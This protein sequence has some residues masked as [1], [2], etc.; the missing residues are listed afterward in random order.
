MS[1]TSFHFH[2]IVA[3][4][5]SGTALAVPA[6]TSAKSAPAA[7]KAAAP[8]TV[9]SLNAASLVPGQGKKMVGVNAF[10]RA[11]VLLDRAWFSPGEIDG[12]QGRNLQRA[13]T[14][15]QMA[16]GLNVNG[17]L[18]AATAK[19]LEAGDKGDAFKTYTITSK[20]VAGPYIK[21]PAPMADRGKL[22]SLDYEN[23]REALAERF[24]ISEAMLVSLNRGRT[25]EF[26]AG[27]E[28]IVP[29]VTPKPPVEGAAKKI[30]IDKSS[31]TLW[32]LGAE[33]KVLGVFPISIGGPQDP[34]P[35]G[36]MKIVNEVPNPG[37]TYNPAILKNTPK[38]AEKVEIAPG[39]NN[40]VGTMWL[41]L[42]KP[43]WG[44][45]GTP[46]PA[47]LGHDETNGCIHLTNWDVQRLARLVK[48][49]FDVDVRP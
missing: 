18:D 42:S 48:P 40:P 43:H 17:R 13:V 22:K 8:L 12:R 38:G 28:I 24:H 10:A 7:V 32:V 30:E 33:R 29:D 6:Q 37:F 26:N 25:T 36:V 20:D 49:G 44:L 11:Q 5:A 46:N 27:D 31:K 21:T 2:L 34:L 4:V 35:I 45:H 23:I 9:D 15:F 16:N 47:K 14:A 3:A 39:P 41:G 19:A 1:T